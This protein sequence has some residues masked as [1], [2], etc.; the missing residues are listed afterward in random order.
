[1][2]NDNARAIAKVEAQAAI[3]AAS[4]DFAG[5]AITE[6][7]WQDRVTKA[8]AAVYLGEDDPRWQ[9]G[10][11][12]D[13][14][15]WRQARELILDA[16]PANGSLLD[17]GCANGYL[18]ECLDTWARDR[19]LDLSLDGL[20]LNLELAE[21]ARRRLPA[22]SERIYIGNITTWVPPRR[23]TYVRTGLEYVPAG[24]ESTLLARLFREVVEPGGRV[25]VGP[26]S[27][28]EMSSTL[29]SFARVTAAKAT[30]VSATDR[31]GKT[32]SVV[33]VGAG[34]AT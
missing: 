2:P 16:V 15:L 5:G 19:G 33:W 34:H 6:T 29:D 14:E 32:R 10:F 27:P 9:S 30:V 11:D 24:R 3:D 20:E 1:M 28:E 25:I 23:F 21:T 31:K 18:L 22:W 4:R 26:I 17:V 12:G 8:L 7:T 13:F